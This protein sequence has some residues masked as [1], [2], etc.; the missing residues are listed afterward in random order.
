[1]ARK[2]IKCVMFFDQ[3]TKTGWAVY[4]DEVL[5]SGVEEFKTRRGESPAMRFHHFSV[6]V[7]MMLDKY[8]PDLCGYEMPHFRGGFATELCVGFATRI[9]EECAVRDVD[10]TNIHSAT[11]KKHITGN[12]KAGKEDVIVAVKKKYPDVNIVDDNHA[13][14]LAG[15]TKLIDD[16]VV[17]F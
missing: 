16:F 5:A 2:S 13:D 4:N 17:P 12:G 6:W 9:Q 14:A 8:K 15:I 7:G 1:M 10:C 11:L 3:A